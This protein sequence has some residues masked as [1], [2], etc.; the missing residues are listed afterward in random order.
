MLNTWCGSCSEYPKLP[1]QTTAPNLMQ[2]QHNRDTATLPLN[3]QINEANYRLRYF[4]G[5]SEASGHQNERQ[6][7]PNTPLQRPPSL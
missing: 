5:E 6:S 4:F 7:R 1:D 3:L 2:F